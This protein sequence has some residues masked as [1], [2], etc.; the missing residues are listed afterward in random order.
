M[1]EVTTISQFDISAAKPSISSSLSI[2]SYSSIIILFFID[3]VE[4]III[5][6]TLE[7]TKYRKLDAAKLLGIGRNTVTRKIKELKISRSIE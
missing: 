2:P 7:Y 6:K 5:E 3:Q 1:L 4:K